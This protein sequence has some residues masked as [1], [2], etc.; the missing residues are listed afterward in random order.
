M[1]E[2][3]DFLDHCGAINNGFIPDATVPPFIVA[4][5]EVGECFDRVEKIAKLDAI[6][7]VFPSGETHPLYWICLMWLE[8]MGLI[9]RSDGEGGL[10]EFYLTEAGVIVLQSL[11][12]RKQMFQ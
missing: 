11:R 12:E 6:L 2:A 4:V 7:P 3:F 10:A 9:E 1:F 8:G 5:L